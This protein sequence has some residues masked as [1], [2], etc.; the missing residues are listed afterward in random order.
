MT[1]VL[2]FSSIKDYVDSVEGLIV[3]CCL[4]RER[5]RVGEKWM[6]LSKNVVRALEEAM[7]VSHSYCDKCLIIKQE[8]IKRDMEARDKRNATHNL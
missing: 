3:G 7:K 5:I 1:N 2:G 8:E 4:C 6:L